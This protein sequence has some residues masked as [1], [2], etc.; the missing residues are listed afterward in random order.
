L[1]KKII[2]I[3]EKINSLKKKRDE[4]NG[5]LNL[6]QTAQVELRKEKE[7]VTCPLCGDGT[8][9]F[10]EITEKLEE[11]RRKKNNFS[12]EILKLNQEKNLSL[13]SFKKIESEKLRLE[14]EL[15][16]KKG[17]VEN[18]KESINIKKIEI[19]NL[20]YDI[21]R[22]KESIKKLEHKFIKLKQG[23]SPEDEKINN[24]YTEKEKERAQISNRITDIET[25]LN[26]ISIEMF[27]FVVDPKI[28]LKISEEWIRIM[29]YYINY[30][31]TKGEEQRK[32][33]SEKFNKNIK[34]LMNNLGFEEFR[35]V[36]LNNEY[37]LYVERLNSKTGD[38]TF[39]QVKSLSTSE[40]LSMALILQL[41]LKETYI[42]DIPFFIL[43]DIIEDFDDERR[44]RVLNYLKKKAEETGWFIITTK[45][46]EEEKPLYIE[47]RN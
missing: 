17:E 35:N 3:D 43:D 8:I 26:Q 21:E 9:S 38:Y 37:K 34:N 27:S 32:K 23:I 4:L 10:N 41:A 46:I 44:E 14:D 15:K 11:L 20:K 1:K 16:N 5:I 39:Q 25:K 33:A 24:L 7:K 19:D 12:A 31:K 6:Y 45:L 22:K 47:V 29:D 30:C 28:A 18:F 36:K 2:E 13:K 42:P 40:K